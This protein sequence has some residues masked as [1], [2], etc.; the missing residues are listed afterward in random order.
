MLV[1]VDTDVSKSP[2]TAAALA[3]RL[4]LLIDVAPDSAHVP[5]DIFL[6]AAS[7][8]EMRACM[9]A[10]VHACVPACT[11]ACARTL[12]HHALHHALVT[13]THRY[14]H[15]NKDRHTDS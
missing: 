4:A 10:R 6:K 7:R 13:H 2:I 3:Q 1:V 8:R 14:G 15:T 12:D 5:D 11:C 9:R